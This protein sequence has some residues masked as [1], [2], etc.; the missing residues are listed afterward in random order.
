MSDPTS[1]PVD[2]QQELLAQL[3]RAEQAGRAG[4]YGEADGICRDVLK[5][6]P[7]LPAAMAM[8]G[9]V[10]ALDGDIEGGIALLEPAIAAEPSNAVWRSTLCDLY[11]LVCRLD[12]ALAVGRAALALAPR[13]A[14]YMVNLGKVFADRLEWD[15]SLA[16]FL[17]ALS[18]EPEN[19]SAHLGIGQILLGLGQFRA[20]WIEYEW[21]NR[22]EQAQGRIPKMNAPVWNG[23]AHPGGRILLIGDQGYGDT[24][25]F[26]R[27]I[28]LV[29]ARCAEVVLGVSEDLKPLLGR[30]PG[31][32]RAFHGWADIPSFTSYCLLS[33]LP[34][35]LGTE[36][37][38]I[39]AASRYL[40]ADPA[41]RDAWQARLAAVLP[42]GQRIGMFWSGRPTHP[43]NKRR[44]VPLARFLAMAA[45]PGV[46]AIALQK[47]MPP[48]DAPVLAASGIADVAAELT[49]FGET[50][51]LVSQLD[52]VITVDSALGHLA[53]ALGI[54]VWVLTPTPS[55]WRWLNDRTDSPWYPSLRLFRQPEPGAWDAVFADVSVALAQWMAARRAA[56]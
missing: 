1:A 54:P 47:E 34:F 50:A 35:I 39:P 44:S 40:E 32:G 36:L 11:R 48:E 16:H 12:D 13:R 42:A 6:H 56:E 15:E 28:P 22:L 29:A 7:N 41:R 4:R 14:L 21:R 26:A 55:D 25:Q 8:R 18:I 23:M 17:A 53:G 30:V 19:P 10:A 52:L 20:G 27:Y 33:S 43:N 5:Q 37:D 24:I 51:A 46:A 9:T 49:D 3:Q 45:M 2:P 31:V 38:S